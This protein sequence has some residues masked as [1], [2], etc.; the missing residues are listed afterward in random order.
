MVS[1]GRTQTSPH[2]DPTC[3]I[4]IDRQWLWTALNEMEDFTL[5]MDALEQVNDYPTF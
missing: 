2:G 1:L 5:L 3:T 4:S